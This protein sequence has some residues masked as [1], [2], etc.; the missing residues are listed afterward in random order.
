MSVDRAQRADY[1][2]SSHP[3]KAKR[4]FRQNLACQATP[5]HLCG[6]A[7]RFTFRLLLLLFRLSSR[8]HTHTHLVLLLKGWFLCQCT[9]AHVCK[10]VSWMT[11]TVFCAVSMVGSRFF[12]SSS[13]SCLPVRTRTHTW[14][15]RRVGSLVSVYIRTSQSRG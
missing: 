14:C 6:F 4:K 2:L 11:P 13:S 3:A 8:A 12:S 10:S 15:C 9:S 5:P 7:G 1:T